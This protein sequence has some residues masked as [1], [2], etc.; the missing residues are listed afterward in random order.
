MTH[1][2]SLIRRP[3]FWLTLALTAAA[4]ILYTSTIQH[5]LSTAWFGADGGDY[6]TAVLTGGVPHP[7]GYPLYLLLSEAAQR[8]FTGSPVTRQALVSALPAALCVGLTFLYIATLLK[9]KPALPR[10]TA[11]AISALC[12]M[13]APLFWGQAVIV[14]VYALNALFTVLILLW[15][16]LSFTCG[17]NP[18]RTALFSLTAL[19][20]VGG[21]G[22]GNHLTLLLILPGT[23]IWLCAGRRAA[24]RPL[25]RELLTALAA[26]AAGLAVYAYLPLTAATSWMTTV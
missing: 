11:A 14:E 25:A 24:G 19:A 22:L 1:F 9:D 10:L 21:L 17:D 2:F 16:E 18:S 4:A 20:W 13:T 15:M 8:I 3:E 6:L 7:T 12:L 5:D 23:A 26:L